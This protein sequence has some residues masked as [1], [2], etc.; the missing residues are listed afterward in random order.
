MLNSIKGK[1]LFT[2]IIG[3]VVNLVM[4]FFLFSS[5]NSLIQGFK[6]LEL[7]IIES[8][9]VVT[10]I[11]KN[12]SLSVQEWK[13]VL[14]R[15]KNPKDLEK[16]WQA[17][18]L[19]SDQTDDEVAEYLKNN[20][21]SSFIASDLRA[22]IKSHQEAV[23]LY[24]QGYLF[25]LDSNFDIALT[26]AKVRGIDRELN[27][28]LVNIIAAIKAHQK[29]ELEQ[30][31]QQS[32][33]L[34]R[35][36]PILFTVV[37]VIIFAVLFIII[38]RLVINPIVQLIENVKNLADSNYHFD[39]VSSQNDE[40][41]DLA[42][43]IQTLK[44]KMSDSVSQVGVVSYQVGSAFD[45]LRNISIKISSGAENQAACV[46]KMQ[47]SVTE[48]QDLSGLLVNNSS[49]AI[50]SNEK[51]D[52]ITNT[53]LE[54]YHGNQQSMTL[55][56][57]EIDTAF[58]TIEKLQTETNNISDIL[59]VIN[60]VAEQTN[61]LAL[62]AAIEAARAGEAGRGFA[63]V[64][65][66]VRSLAIKT[67]QSTEMIN[68]VITSLSLSSGNAVTAMTKGQKLTAENAMKATESVTFLKNIFIEVENMKEVILSV[69]EAA[70]QQNII[71][72]DISKLVGDIL[73]YSNEYNEIA[74]ESAIS[75]SMLSASTSLTKL[76]DGLSENTPDD[77]DEL[78]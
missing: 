2:L 3:T 64:A 24:K 22:F 9:R 26:D 50:S 18:L 27:L 51:V 29:E 46:E 57:S 53:C 11:N 35:L 44:E 67:R 43:H 6:T 17:F 5:F 7:H 56:V 30:I 21:M 78:F 54:A 58:D 63:V 28:Q 14:I 4:L 37:M 1:T 12:L 40:L 77:S 23:S 13:N 74:N 75:D 71:S 69:E 8:E 47:N 15:G 66:E 72:I 76:S 19:H 20:E 61:L 34:Q 33:D 31:Y 42:D 65:D 70:N 49:S 68:K 73:Y 32:D 52:N 38:S 16:Y 36:L 25:Y 10:A 62:N 60:S 55:L 41:G 39:I 48:L 45:Q 59:E